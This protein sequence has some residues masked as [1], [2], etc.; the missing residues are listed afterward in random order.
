M[1]PQN[2]PNRINER[3]G[4][5]DEIA[6]DSNSD[7]QMIYSGDHSNPSLGKSSSIVNERK[8]FNVNKIIEEPKSTQMEE[9]LINKIQKPQIKKALTKGPEKKSRSPSLKVSKTPKKAMTIRPERTFGLAKAKPTGANTVKH[10]KTKADPTD[11]QK[12]KA[13]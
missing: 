13:S 4:P 5:R 11:F 3:S 9:S 8:L 6:E 12:I 1:R 10:K 7:T 2:H